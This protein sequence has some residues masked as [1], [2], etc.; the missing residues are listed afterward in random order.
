MTC[1]ELGIERDSRGTYRRPRTNPRAEQERYCIVCKVWRPKRAS[2][3][4]SCGMCIERHDHH[5]SA[6]GTCIGAGNHRFFVC[7][8]ISIAMSSCLCAAANWSALSRMGW[9]A[10][11]SAWRSG[12]SY[13]ALLLALGTTYSSGL[14]FFACLHCWLMSA[15]LTSRELFVRRLS[16]WHKCTRPGQVVKE[17]GNLLAF[18]V[19]SRCTRRR[20]VIAALPLLDEENNASGSEDLNEDERDDYENAHRRSRDVFLS[21]DHRSRHT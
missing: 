2:H 14:L 17:A 18:P 1:E 4:S 16:P 20:R 7:F 12:R 13:A 15:D 6:I 3:C 10:T 21:D 5:C 8:L 11:G 9:P 19:R